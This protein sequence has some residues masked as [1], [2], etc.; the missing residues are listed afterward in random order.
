MAPAKT[1]CDWL[2]WQ[3]ADSAFPT[4]GFAHSS[5]LE[6][7][8]QH[9]EVR[10]RADFHGWLLASLQQVARG[11]IPWLN[12]AYQQPTRL[13]ELDNRCDAFTSNHVA[14]RASR[15]QGRALLTAAERIFGTAFT[16]PTLGHFAP[17]FGVVGRTLEIPH[18]DTVRLCVYWHLKGVIAAAVRL[19]IMG[20]MEAQ[21][22]Q[23]KMGSVAEAVVQ[24]G[25]T[26]DLDDLAQT[27]PV[28]ELWQGAHDRLYSRLFQS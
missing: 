8:W 24:R 28:Q 5:G 20:P 4:G 1:S 6:A 13:E 19:N 12:M 25:A 2:R 27:N 7:A 22:L 16:P 17:I 23:H 14:N 3:L 15:L 26:Y 10:N 11:Q 9:D 21:G 18:L